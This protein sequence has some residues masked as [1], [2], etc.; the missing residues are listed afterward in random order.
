MRNKNDIHIFAT[1]EEFST[2]VNVRTDFASD[3]EEIRSDMKRG[4]MTIVDP[5]SMKM[6][7]HK[8]SVFGHMLPEPRIIAL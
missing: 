1:S 2:D 8:T 6:S 4:G 7:C 5:E 3:I